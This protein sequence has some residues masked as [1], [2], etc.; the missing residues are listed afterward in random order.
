MA[1]L[2]RPEPQAPSIEDIFSEECAR[3]IAEEAGIPYGPRLVFDL[4]LAA[5]SYLIDKQYLRFST[6][7][8]EKSA[9][10]IHARDEQR[11]VLELLHK[12]SSALVSTLSTIGGTEHR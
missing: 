4:N 3:Q 2:P 12:Q 8:E 5:S 11:K 1:K 9:P 10:Q 6:T 7:A